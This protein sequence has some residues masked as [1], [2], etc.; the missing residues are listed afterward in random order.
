MEIGSNIFECEFTKLADIMI[1]VQT[2][3]QQVNMVEGLPSYTVR[4]CK[5]VG[6]ERRDVTD[7]MYV[8][9]YPFVDPCDDRLAEYCKTNALD[10]LTKKEHDE[11]KAKVDY[12]IHPFCENALSAELIEQIDQTP[13]LGILVHVMTGYIATFDY[14]YLDDMFTM[15]FHA[16][17]PSLIRIIR[18]YGPV[19]KYANKHD[20]QVISKSIRDLL[21]QDKYMKFY[22][23]SYRTEEGGITPISKTITGT[24]QDYNM[25]CLAYTL[26]LDGEIVEKVKA[27]KRMIIT[28]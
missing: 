10:S 9:P 21:L 5:E 18:K 14:R 25:M 19:Q 16:N 28:V 26:T 22:C 20:R 23:P 6:E 24:Y 13:Y 12:R 17:L 1:P 7:T 8:L 4:L 2:F 11:W 3:I 27:R 15:T